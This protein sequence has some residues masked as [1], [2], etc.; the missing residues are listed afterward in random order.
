[1]PA[2]KPHDA[3]CSKKARFILRANQ[4]KGCGELTVRAASFPQ[5]FYNKTTMNF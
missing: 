5:P 2:T 1:M 3:L 4:Q